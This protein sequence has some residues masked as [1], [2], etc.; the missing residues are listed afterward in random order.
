MTVGER[1]IQLLARG[2][3]PD[4]FQVL[5]AHQVGADEGRVAVRA[6]V[7]GAQSVS[8][9]GA[10]GTARPLARLHPD[11]FFEA[12]LSPAPVVPYQL[13]ITHEGGAVESI[14]DPYSF[15][16]R[17]G[18]PDLNLFSAGTHPNIGG[19]LGAHPLVSHGVSGVGFAVWAP[20]ARRVSVVGDFNAWDGRRHPMRLHGG[21]GVWEIFLPGVEP[22]ALY[23]FEIKTQ[24]GELLLKSDPYGSGME[25]RPQ[26]ASIVQGR[27]EG[28]PGDG[29]WMEARARTDQRRAPVAI[30]EV[31]LGSWR[32]GGDDRP[33]TYPELA[34]E[35]V[36]YVK[37]MGFTH[38]ELLPVMEHPLDESWGYQV[39]GYFAPTSRHGTPED[40]RCFV[41]CCHRN[42][43]G[44]ILDWVPA[45]FPQDGHGLARF[46]GTC[47]YE[48]AD[49]RRGFHPDWGTLIFDYG[50]AEVRNF[51]CANALYWLEEFRVDGLR[52]DAV[53]SMLY[54][55]YSRGDGEWLPNRHGGRENLEAIDFVRQLN[56]A[57]SS[58][59]PGAMMIAEESTPWPGVSRP[60][61]AGGLGFDFKWNMGWM[62]DTL[63]YFSREPAGRTA[64]HD[65]LTSGLGNAFQENYV[66]PLSHDEVVHEKGSLLGKMPGDSRARFANL[67]LLYGYMYGHP[68]KKHLFMGGEIGQETEWDCG[69]GLDWH[70]LAS[71]PH[72]RLW[73][74]VADLNRLYRSEP[75][76]F[77]G[78][79]HEAGFEWIDFS[80]AEHSVLA[81][82]RHALGGSPS[83]LF[84]FNFGLVARHDYRVGVPEAGYYREVL[85]SDAECYGGSGLGNGDGLASARV[86]WHGKPCSLRMVLPPLTVVVLK[87][88]EALP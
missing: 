14:H 24:A 17:L 39:V 32:R 79:C 36:P 25:L 86:P 40:F 35:M 66:L 31:H 37:E 81:F 57:V 28:S 5:G 48:Y 55:D 18:D 83:L 1:D 43:I 42:G 71:W 56:R 16:P 77:E 60:P 6:F 41:D 84:V 58:R 19:E 26:S 27:A 2:E 47:L 52:V 85:N 88:V 78:D 38:L 30:Y 21:S 23:K 63:E 11:G 76:F 34:R 65:L 22:G 45:H 20:A 72:A 3:H 87:P 13:E 69:R 51:L 9:L 10:S 33:L 8:V 15:P 12:V 53:S 46:D 67:R 7:P 75:A 61:G 64:H 73:R 49:P 82:M 59:V 68:G 62:N 50:R 74:F 4:P 54:L 29:E 80:D 70:L 44:V